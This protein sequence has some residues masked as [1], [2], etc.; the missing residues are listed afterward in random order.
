MPPSEDQSSL[1]PELFAP[2]SDDLNSPT[3]YR[4]KHGAT[5]RAFAGVICGIIAGALIPSA[6]ASGCLSYFPE[7][8]QR[9]AGWIFLWGEHWAIRVV[10]SWASAAGAG[11]ITGIIA[12]RRGRLLAAIAALPATLCWLVIALIGWTQKVPFLGNQF[13][14]DFSI[15]NKLAA[16]LLVFTII[17]FA[18]YGGMAG[19]ESGEMFGE[20]F[21]SRNYTLLGIKWYHYLWLPIVIQLL[22][23]Q[24]A[25]TSLYA[26]DWFRN[27]WRAGMSLISIVPSLFAFA[28]LCTI[29][30]MVQG[31]VRAY[32][33][34]SG[35]EEVPSAR[36]RAFR[37]LKYGFGFPIVAAILQAGISLV[38]YGLAKLLTHGSE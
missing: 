16:S 11:F 24:T 27:T 13:E 17:P 33:I 6:L 7:E 37:V 4:A 32:E 15:G 28:I 20:H 1:N 26:F 30:I 18:C 31:A 21:D 3:A 34:L 2:R 14:V 9:A 29:S 10:A 5:A 38:H 12:R 19:E 36:S 25:W 23:V 22:L 35:I 8:R